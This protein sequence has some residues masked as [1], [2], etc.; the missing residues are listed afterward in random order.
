MLL[1]Q[2]GVD[3]KSSNHFRQNCTIDNP[4]NALY[5]IPG[6]LTHYFHISAKGQNQDL[7]QSYFNPMKGHCIMRYGQYICPGFQRDTDE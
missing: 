6:G 4:I 1:D 7:I 3:P 5:A 2:C